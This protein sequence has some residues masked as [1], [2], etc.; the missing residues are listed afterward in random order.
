MVTLNDRGS[1]AVKVSTEQ[2]GIEENY[3]PKSEYDLL[4]ERMF[5]IASAS[6]PRKLN[7]NP[8]NINGLLSN[9]N[10]V[11]KVDKPQVINEKGFLTTT[12]FL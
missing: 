12:T 1:V 10:L 9:K 11:V 6:N 4:K 2:T 5:K 7:L 3:L 8:V